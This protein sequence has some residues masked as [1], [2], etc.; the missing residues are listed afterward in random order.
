MSVWS[1]AQAGPYPE[2]V[3]SLYIRVLL[4]LPG[5]V[6]LR[7]RFTAAFRNLGA[8]AKTNLTHRYEALC[9]HYGM[10][11]AHTNR[12]ITHENGA[13]ESAHGHLKSAARDPRCCAAPRPSQTSRPIA[14]SSPR[15]SGRGTAAIMT[16]G[17]LRSWRRKSK[18]LLGSA[19]V[20]TCHSAPPPEDGVP[21][22][23]SHRP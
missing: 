23:S 2:R 14:A 11:P 19:T 5:G 16:Y 17:G 15:S 12:G 13:I 21:I 10:T 22:R 9:V 20:M 3:S 7:R 18:R 1:G 6:P 8:E 4:A